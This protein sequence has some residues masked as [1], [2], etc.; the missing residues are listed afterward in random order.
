MILGKQFPFQSW[1]SLHQT[2]DTKAKSW[3]M[4]F[5]T[6]ATIVAFSGNLLSRT[7]CCFSCSQITIAYLVNMS[8]ARMSLGDSPVRPVGVRAPHLV[9]KDRDVD[10]VVVALVTSGLD[11]QHL[12]VLV[13]RQPAC[14]DSPSRSSPDYNTSKEI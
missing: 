8:L 13:L 10:R 1:I 4:T 11:Q 12:D 2:N 3:S 7:L 5:L 9:R 14:E 6:M